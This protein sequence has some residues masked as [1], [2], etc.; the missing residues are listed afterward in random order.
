MQV[1]CETL[2]SAFASGEYPSLF[3]AMFHACPY[4]GFIISESDRDRYLIQPTVEDKMDLR[5]RHRGA[6]TF[7]QFVEQL[8]SP[9]DEGTGCGPVNDR[10]K[11][12]AQYSRIWSSLVFVVGEY[13]NGRLGFLLQ[14][15]IRRPEKLEES[16]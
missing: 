2:E 12:W 16:A 4:C 15:Q 9:D 3:A 7:D 1:C 13:K 6:R 5:N 8:G 14:P 10:W 11:R